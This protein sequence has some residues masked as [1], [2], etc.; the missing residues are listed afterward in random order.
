MAWENLDLDRSMQEPLLPILA[1]EAEPP[2]HAI[3][4]SEGPGPSQPPD[5]THQEAATDIPQQR[6]VTA[7][8][9]RRVA[10]EH[11][12]YRVCTRLIKSSPG[13]T[14][15]PDDTDE[16]IRHAL[17]EVGRFTG[18]DRCY[19][20]EKSDDGTAITG[21]YEWCAQGIGSEIHQFRE[22]PTEAFPWLW[23]QIEQ[24]Q[25]VKVSSIDDLPPDAG[26]EKKELIRQGV[27]SIVNIPIL[28]GEKVVGLIG[29]HWMRSPWQ[30]WLVPDSSQL[31]SLRNLFANALQHKRVERALWKANRV[32]RAVLECSDALIRAKDEQVLLREVCRIIVEIG[33]YPLAW[34]GF[35]QGDRSCSVK[36]VAQ[37]G[38]DRGYLDKLEIRWADIERGRGPMGK[39]I[40]TRAPVAVQNVATD[41]DFK[42]WRDAAL[43]RGF[44][45]VLAVS[46]VFGDELLGALGVYSTESDSFD[47][48]E[49]EILQRF[50]DYLSYGIVAL[51]SRVRQEVAE[52]QLRASLRSKDDLIASISHELRTPL[53][54]VVGFAQVLED[55][56]S[57][58][59]A[60]ERAEMIRSII[61][62][63][64]DL[65]N[66]VEDLLTAAKAEAGTLTVVHVPVDLRAQAAQV[67]EALS[68]EEAR[69]VEVSGTEGRATGDPGRVRQILRN[70]ISNA[71][72]YGG[73]RIRVD[74]V[75]NDAC[76]VQVTDNGIG[77]PVEERERIF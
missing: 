9:E 74:V 12:I 16:A 44:R 18:A 46:L 66:I 58:L 22:V 70:L 24:G 57:G 41:P 2:E 59:S 14:T 39:A 8:L 36:P 50:A 6:L 42:I 52:E 30:Q 5:G 31:A 32:L 64:L 55:E 69:Q 11:L 27:R 53:T 25:V 73:D 38:F 49:I 77:G 67:I 71:L 17:A 28:A 29:I 68:Q 61:E 76:R 40:R 4:N 35:D 62:E 75:E 10:F 45:S 1:E 51:R 3:A 15:A 72:R 19:V 54:A 47:A 60:P 23:N 63:G 20:L 43:K 26:A 56:E 33:G 21:R 37:W 13:H 65:T 48:L 34:V 7:E